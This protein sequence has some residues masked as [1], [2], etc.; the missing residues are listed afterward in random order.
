MEGSI[1]I[2]VVV[3]HTTRRFPMWV[4]AWLV[5]GRSG[6]EPGHSGVPGKL[7]DGGRD[8]FPECC[9]TRVSRYRTRAYSRVIVARWSATVARRSTPSVCRAA[10]TDGTTLQNVQ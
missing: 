5:G 10:T 8:E 3:A 1:P 4:Q 7:D 9:P 6:R 2:K